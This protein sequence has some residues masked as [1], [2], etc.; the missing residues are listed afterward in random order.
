VPADTVY[1]C[2]RAAAVS[3]PGIST[4]LPGVCASLSLSLSL[5]LTFLLSSSCFHSHPPPLPM[6]CL[7]YFDADTVGLD[8]KGMVEDLTAAPDGSIVLLHGE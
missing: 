6:C 8:F 4:F 7:R 1:V 3:H 2:L 5:A